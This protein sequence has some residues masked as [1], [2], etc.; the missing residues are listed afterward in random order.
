MKMLDPSGIVFNKAR[1]RLVV[2][3]LRG[4][5]GFNSGSVSLEGLH[6]LI[7]Y[8]IPKRSHAAATLLNCKE[9]VITAL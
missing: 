4:S 6:H 2:V 9:K 7:V 3:A 5:Q 1:N 8:L